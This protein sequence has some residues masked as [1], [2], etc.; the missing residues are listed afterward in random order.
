MAYFLSPSLGTFG[1]LGAD[2]VGPGTEADQ[3]AW[4]LCWGL[5]RDPEKEVEEERKRKLGVTVTNPLPA[6]T[7]YPVSSLLRALQPSPLPIHL[8]RQL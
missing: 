3:V 6:P 8:L 7:A 1:V 5:S 2:P 4:Q